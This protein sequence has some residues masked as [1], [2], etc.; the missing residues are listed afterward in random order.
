MPEI[1]KTTHKRIAII[2]IWWSISANVFL[3]LIWI[4]LF[5]DLLR[6]DT[7]QGGLAL[8]TN[9]I[10]CLIGVLMLRS[11]E[12]SEKIRTFISYVLMSVGLVELTGLIILATFFFRPFLVFDPEW[13]GYNMIINNFAYLLLSWLITSTTITKN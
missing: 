10:P 9:L 13:G 7:F 1:L 6:N 8:V 4:F 2:M 12:D 3:Y 11:R 5:P